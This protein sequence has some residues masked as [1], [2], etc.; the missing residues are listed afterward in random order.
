MLP[1]AH[2]VS[3]SPCRNDPEKALDTS[4]VISTPEFRCGRI[5]QEHV[6]NAYTA[7]VYPSAAGQVGPPAGTV[8]THG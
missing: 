2:V 3:R 7:S 8:R 5:I 6:R 4:P 1:R